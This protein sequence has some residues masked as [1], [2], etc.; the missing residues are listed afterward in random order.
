MTSMR[1]LIAMAL[2]PAAALLGAALPAHAASPACDQAWADYNEFKSTN[3]M[4]P[5]QY[6]LTM[7]GAAVRAACGKN[8]LPAPPGAD[9]PPRV[10]ARRAQ[11]GAT[12]AVVPPAKAATGAMGTM[13]RP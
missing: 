6:A 11:P 1:K 8:A 7:Q 4:D 5:S 10:R 2:F 13:A 9:L 3:S 12:T